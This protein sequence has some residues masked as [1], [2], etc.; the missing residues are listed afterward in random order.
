MATQT[1]NNQALS[2]R[3]SKSITRPLPENL[4]LPDNSSAV[5]TKLETSVN[6]ATNQVNSQANIVAPQPA[7]NFPSLNDEAR[8]T[9]PALHG[10][11]G[12]NHLIT[13]LNG[14]MRIQN[15][16]GEKVANINMASFWSTL[17]KMQ[18]FDDKVLFDADQKRWIITAY[19]HTE[20]TSSAILIAVSQTE[21]ALGNWY[22]YR[23]NA[24]DKASNKS[25]DNQ[26]LIASSANA[27]FNKQW[28]VV[29]S[30]MFTAPAS[31]NSSASFAQSN[32]IVFNKADLYAGG[33]GQFTLIAAPNIGASQ[34]PVVSM[35]R[36]ANDLFLVQNYNGNIGNGGFLALYKISGALGAESMTRIGFPG[37]EAAWLSSNTSALD[38]APQANIKQG[39]Q[40]SDANI[41]NAI[42]RNGS[43]WATQTIFLP[44]SENR[45]IS[46]IQWWEL[47]T[48]GVVKQQGRIADST[49]QNYY[50]A[51]SLAVN[52]QNDLLIGYSS[53]SANTFVSA[54]Y[55]FRSASDA[56]G[57]MR[58]GNTIKAGEQVFLNL[59]D[60]GHNNWLAYSGSAVDPIDDLALWTVQ[61]FAAKSANGNSRIGSQW[62][63]LTP[64]VAPTISAFTPTSG[65]VGTPVTITGTGFTGAAFVSFNNISATFNV[66]SDTQINAMV[67]TGASNGFIVVSNPDGSF[68]SANKFIVA[69]ST[70]SGF[71]P[72]GGI[73]GSTV[74][75]FGTNLTGTT[76][77]RFNNTKAINFTVTSDTQITA[78]VPDGAKT[79]L[80][81][82]VTPSGE[83]SS[84][85]NFNVIPTST[86]SGF[87]PT[88]GPIGVRVSIFGTNLTNTTAVSFGN[89]PAPDFKIPSDTQINVN[90]P[91]GAISGPIIVTTPGGVLTSTDNFIVIAS[92]TI[93]GF[94][95]N[96][97]SVGTPVTIFGTNF[98]GASSLKFNGAT[99]TF[100]VDTPTQITT[101]V[102][103][104]A[105]NGPI[106]ITTPGGV[107]TTSSNFTVLATATLSG[108][109]PTSGAPGTNISIFGT[110]FTG[111]SVVKF[112]GVAATS[113]KVVSDTQINTSVPVGALSGP[114]SVT[115]PGGTITSTT[116]FIV[117]PPTLTTFSPNSGPV[118]TVVSISG[119]GL[120]S[121][122]GVSF[123]GL[124]TTNF[125]VVSDTQ[126]TV[127]VPTG[128]TTGQIS[129]MSANGSATSGA[130]FTVIPAP[131]IA[132]FT[133]TSG[134][135]G[136]IVTITGNNFNG[137]TSVSFNG[138]PATSF[139]VISATQINATV[140]TGATTGPITVATSAG[141]I[142]SAT[143]F[144]IN[145]P[146]FNISLS[147]D[148]LTVPRTQSGVVNV[149]IIRTGGF[150]GKVTVSVPDTSPLKIKFTLTSQTTKASTLTF[151]FKVKKKAA[152]GPQTIVFTAQDASGKVATST[153]TLNIQ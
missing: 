35:D 69:A 82:V 115:T 22:Q 77:V 66:V 14:K 107:V 31:G 80:I 136:T 123:N 38:N 103:A 7:R 67:P 26:A 48:N 140:P 150:T 43:I 148:Q 90:V 63:Q 61:P 153:F 34:I 113:I 91:A 121:I 2:T 110:N 89:V 45:L 135:A 104:G 50:A 57:T 20:A 27:G 129:L 37:T 12:I 108:F 41:Q 49:G 17:G 98:V 117:P 55:A 149:N 30:N 131:T 6:Q 143:A 42:Y 120:A 146:G 83:I 21:D 28:I 33:N 16:T 68:T 122:S 138:I 96:S 106:A 36:E 62:I 59:D 58:M 133:P 128:A 5:A 73:V 147:P 70:L 1:A 130:I 24:R 51:P 85:K 54:N 137:A 93:S 141:T 88:S 132:T 126:I 118:G 152:V 114:I 76:E 79:G 99:A 56:P 116:N 4:P 13:I 52:R 81:T 109:S 47:D 78:I 105:T 3:R 15:K 19:A 11:A 112:N 119:A 25:S 84:A 8:G 23:V 97:G 100:T 102:P 65:P 92:P 144:T 72:N 139:S 151:N 127:P 29:Q 134:S 18:T 94:T 101:T 10:T 39:L 53:F 32:I 75:I 74:N 64:K 145:G 9:T 124:V 95:P 46:A 87:T 86:L 111:A 71:S 142:N 40:N 125:T 44:T 60:Q